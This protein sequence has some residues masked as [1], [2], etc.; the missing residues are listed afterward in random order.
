MAEDLRVS[1]SDD[2]DM[3]RKDVLKACVLNAK[4]LH[5]SATRHVAN[6]ASFVEASRDLH[7]ASFQTVRSIT[8]FAKLLYEQSLV[9]EA[10]TARRQAL[11]AIDE[12]GAVLK[13]AMPGAN[14]GKLGF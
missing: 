12:L 2:V 5:E 13:N 8:V 4:S 10:E 14:A 9:A 6:I 1:L 3:L 11:A 7:E